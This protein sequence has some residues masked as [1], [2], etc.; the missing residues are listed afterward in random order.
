[1][2]HEEK[3]PPE[4]DLYDSFSGDESD[5]DSLND[6]YFLQRSDMRVSSQTSLEYSPTSPTSS[7]TAKVTDNTM[8]S[9]YDPLHIPMMNG[10]SSLSNHYQIGYGSLDFAQTH[11]IHE[12]LLLEEA[13]VTESSLLS[14]GGGGGLKSN[15]RQA[16]S[17]TGKEKRRLRQ[18]R[19]KQFE[20]M[21]RERIVQKIRGTMQ[22]SSTCRD[23]IFA[24]L[25][26]VQLV[27]VLF[28]AIHFFGSGV[29]RFD[30]QSS[31]SRD[32]P[33]ESK[34]SRFLESASSL[35]DFVNGNGGGP[36]KQISQVATSFVLNYQAVMSIVGITG[37]YASILSLLTVGFMLIIV[38]SLIQTVLVFCILLSLAWGVMW[39][40]LARQQHGVVAILG[41]VA[42]ILMVGYTIVVWDRIPFAAT[43]LHTALA[44]MQSTADITLLGMSMLL[45]AF[46]WCLVWCMAFIGLVDTLDV[47]EPGDKAC[48]DDL[49]NHNNIVLYVVFFL[50]FCWTNQVIKVGW[51]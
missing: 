41:F 49:N 1:M 36:A 42:F 2:S 46:A 15:N 14:Y 51:K 22:D 16:S 12:V 48:R 4:N 31:F 3:E 18:L 23:F 11:P 9:E 13:K 26:V 44:A 29:M 10:L 38:K 33:K 21:E 32:A 45:V 8:C 50:S 35:S 27:L 19:K 25:F 43:N 6:A 24:A 34:G 7:K 5:S 47:C 40:A 39:Y 37:L 30:V 17:L 28:C 20:Q